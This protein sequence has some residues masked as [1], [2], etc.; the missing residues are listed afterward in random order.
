MQKKR[1][2][3]S[4]QMIGN[5]YAKVGTHESMVM[6]LPVHVVDGLYACLEAE[7]YPEPNKRDV[8]ELALNVLQDYIEEKTGKVIPRPFI[9]DDEEVLQQLDG[10]R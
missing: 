3:K 10:E 4:K 8:L 6:R 7:E 5:Q 2:G 1:P 9:H